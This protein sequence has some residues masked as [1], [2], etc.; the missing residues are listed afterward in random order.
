MKR[1]LDECVL[2]RFSARLSSDVHQCLT[3]PEAGFA[4][5]TNGE[6]LALAEAGFD[7]FLTLD[8]GFAY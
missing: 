4:G 1:V 7:V 5:K 3:V 8:K 2:C 6:L